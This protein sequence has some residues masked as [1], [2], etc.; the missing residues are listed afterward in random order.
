MPSLIFF[1][2]SNIENCMLRY[3]FSSACNFSLYT[4]DFSHFKN[5]SLFPRFMVCSFTVLPFSAVLSLAFA[6]SS[7]PF[8]SAT[9]CESLRI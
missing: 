2:Y 8:S 5:I 7:L 9:S 6:A 3:F 1:S 4:M